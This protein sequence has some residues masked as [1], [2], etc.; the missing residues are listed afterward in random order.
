MGVAALISWF[1][2]AFVG[3]SVVITHGVLAV[4]TVTLVVLAM[5]GVGAG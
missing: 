1:V 4:T 3:L 5:L 2:T